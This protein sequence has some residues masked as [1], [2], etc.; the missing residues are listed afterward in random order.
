MAHGVIAKNSPE[1]HS[2]KSIKNSATTLQKR[3]ALPMYRSPLSMRLTRNEDVVLGV[4]LDSQTA[5]HHTVI[6]ALHASGSMCESGLNIVKVHM[7][8]LRKELKPLGVEIENIW[9]RGY[10]LAD[11]AKDKLREMGCN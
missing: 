10:T 8:H 1:K 3:K 9:G 5:E 11:G 6:S 2:A 7:C 4:L